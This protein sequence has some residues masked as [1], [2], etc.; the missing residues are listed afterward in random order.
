[1]AILNGEL[2]V[3]YEGKDIT[4][5]DIE[6]YTA[7]RSL[8]IPDLGSVQDMTSCNRC[9]CIYVADPSNKKIHRIPYK[10]TT[11]NWRVNGTPESLSVTSRSNL[12]VVCDSADNIQE[13]TTDGKLVREIKL[14]SDIVNLWH[15]VEMCPDQLL[16]C[17]GDTNDQLHRVCIMDSNGCI[18]Q[19]YGGTKGSGREHMYVPV[20]IA[21]NGFIFVS[22]LNNGRV[23]MLS[24]ELSYIREVVSGLRYPFRMFFDE[25]NG[26]LYV[27]DNYWENGNYVSGNIKVFSV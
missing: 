2:Y 22:D 18:L 14:Q 21:V 24:P 8:Q 19:S 6:T 16:V 12:L 17:H 15:A 26:K 3:R 23:F 7:Q 5:Y 20:R 25:L 13:F 1:M 10:N 9:Q 4:V 27:A 11:M